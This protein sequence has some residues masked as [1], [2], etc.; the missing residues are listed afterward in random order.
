M[1]RWFKRMAAC[2]LVLALVVPAFSVPETA[3]AASKITLKSGAAAPSTI[4]AGHSYTLDV[5]GA[6]VKYYSSN[7]KIA[8]IGVTTGK[9]KPTEPGSVKITAKSKKTGKV[10]AFKTFKVLK[11]STSVSVSPKTVYLGKVGD[12]AQLQS[13]LKPANSTDVVRYVTSDKTIATIGL[14]SGRVTAKGIGKTTIQVYAKA[15]KATS[16]SNKYNKKTTVDVYVGP[17]LDQAEQT[18]L[19]QVKL[20]FK[21]SVDVYAFQPS[22]F[23]ITNDETKVNCPIKAVSKSSGSEVTLTLYNELR[24]GK[25]YTVKNNMSAAQFTATDARIAGLRIEPTEAEIQKSTQISLAL[26]DKNGIIVKRCYANNTPSNI[27]FEV[28]AEGGYVFYGGMLYLSS[29][30]GKGIAKA[31]YHS[32]KFV[33]GKEVGNIETGEVII[34]PLKQKEEEEEPIYSGGSDPYR[35]QYTI[36]EEIPRQAETDAG[37]EENSYDYDFGQPIQTICLGQAGQIESDDESSDNTKTESEQQSVNARFQIKYNGTEVD[38]YRNY[39]VSVLDT[40]VVDVSG[41]STTGETSGQT[42]QTEEGKSKEVH[43]D[44]NGFIQ[45]TP[46]KVGETKL[47]LR[48]EGKVIRNLPITVSSEAS[49]PYKIMFVKNNELLHEDKV[50][51]CNYPDYTKDQETPSTDNMNDAVQILIKDQYG[52]VYNGDVKG[53]FE[54]AGYRDDQL[55]TIDTNNNS[56][57]RV[58]GENLR[59][60]LFSRSVHY[61][62]N[63]RT[64]LYRTLYIDVQPPTLAVTWDKASEYDPKNYEGSTY[65]YR[66]LF[67]ISDACVVTCNGKVMKLSWN[68]EHYNEL[69]YYRI[70]AR[71]AIDGFTDRDSLTNG[72][73]MKL[74]KI[75]FYA[76]YNKSMPPI[77]YTELS[78]I[79]FGKAQTESGSDTTGEATQSSGNQEQGPEPSNPSAQLPESGKTE[80]GAAASNAAAASSS[81]TESDTAA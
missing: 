71:S 9:L 1:N 37:S 41:M 69:G 17:Y 26:L 39:T 66:D 38:D 20:T 31:T 25:S 23:T 53:N 30:K 45:L 64:L 65:A 8:T 79:T 4:Y 51:V 43:L 49:K 14:T 28:K 29:M 57:I 24:D 54:F 3:A 19:A 10:V 44:P 32:G 81:V 68:G 74:T 11:R 35:V 77:S 50:E 63:N 27:D 6:N 52:A 33:N 5:K 58:N 36:E 61:Y 47:V 78:T 16:S 46:Y 62:V 80:S 72:G 7:K 60:M 73:I 42:E 18:Q 55:A 56:C 12:T 34:T 13:T 15:T 48:H 2:L 70:G 40:N 67:I 22:D 75:Y 21:D 76:T 59:P